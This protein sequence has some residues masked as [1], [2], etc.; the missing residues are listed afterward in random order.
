MIPSITP[1]PLLLDVVRRLNELLELDP[2][3]V[4]VF[5]NATHPANQA[6][7]DSD[8]FVVSE[9]SSSPTGY[10]LR[11]VGLLNGLVVVPG[12]RIAVNIDHAS[13][14]DDNVTGFSPYKLFPTRAD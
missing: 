7:V 1:P 13:G 4:H 3:L 9:M 10:G 8:H 5:V 2:E 14:V 11:L 6:V 12:W